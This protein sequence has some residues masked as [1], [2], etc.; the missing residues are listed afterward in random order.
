MVDYSCLY[1]GVMNPKSLTASV[2]GLVVYA[3]PLVGEGFS[4]ILF[5]HKFFAKI[6]FV[7]SQVL[8]FLI[9]MFV[10]TAYSGKSKVVLF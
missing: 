4:S 8:V 6:S 3:L 7:E 1:L 2:Y 9:L 10:F 5:A